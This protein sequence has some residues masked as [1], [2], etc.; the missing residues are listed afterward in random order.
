MIALLATVLAVIVPS[1]ADG[2]DR[3]L[4]RKAQVR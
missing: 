1:I 4:M 2:A 3:E